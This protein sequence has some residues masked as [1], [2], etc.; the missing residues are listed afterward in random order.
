MRQS[1]YKGPS[2][3]GLTPHEH[4]SLINILNDMDAGPLPMFDMANWNYCLA[5][6]C[7]RR[8][9]TRFAKSVWDNVLHATI[10]RRVDRIFTQVSANQKSV[11]AML[12]KFLQTGETPVLLPLILDTVTET[13]RSLSDTD[14]RLLEQSL[15]QRSSVREEAVA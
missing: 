7:D 14:L 6:Q 13:I 10:Y 12:R 3:L 1:M 2:E 15:L 4:R 9:G 11:A 5:G 8:Y